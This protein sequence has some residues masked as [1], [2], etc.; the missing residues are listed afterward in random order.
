M[1]HKVIASGKPNRWGCK[2]P[3]HSNWNLPLFQSLLH[4]YDDIEIIQY[5]RYGFPISRDNKQVDPTPNAV[6]HKRATMFPEEVDKYFQREIK[7][8]ATMGP[9]RIPPFI[10]RIGVSPISTRPKKDSNSRRIILDLSFPEGTSVNDGIDKNFYCRQEISLKYPTINT[11][12]KRV[13]HLKERS[14]TVLLWK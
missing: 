9:F 13:L 11:L 10:N 2:I 1:A 12:A 8:G 14:N 7:E 5:L 4:D 3:I 6:N